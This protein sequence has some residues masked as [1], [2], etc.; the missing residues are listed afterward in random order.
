MEIQHHMY[1]PRYVNLSN[2]GPNLL[3]GDTIFAIFGSCSILV[4]IISWVL[5]GRFTKTT[6]LERLLICWFIYNG[7]LDLT[8]KLSFLLNPDFYKDT[9]GNYFAEIW[10][11][12]SKGDLRYA[13]LDSAVVCVHG[14]SIL[15]GGL[16]CLFAVYAIATHKSYNLVLQLTISLWHCYGFTMYYLTAILDGSLHHSGNPFYFYAYFIGTKS[17]WA[18]IPLLILIRC[19][20]KICESEIRNKRKIQ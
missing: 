16:N 10:K 18:L 12:F 13:S 15:I 14:M 3:S 9:S 6:K 8:V 5:S 19:W 4:I 17:P 2:F 7:V 1:S 11:E 20:R